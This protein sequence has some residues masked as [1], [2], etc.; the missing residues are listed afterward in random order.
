MKHT[1]D[2]LTAVKLFI[3]QLCDKRN[4]RTQSALCAVLLWYVFLFCTFPFGSVTSWDLSTVVT[5]RNGTPMS[6]SLSEEEEWSLSLPLEEMGYWM[7]RIAVA[8]EDRRY[9]SH[10]GIDLISILRAAAQNIKEGKII[11]GGSTITSQV[12]RLGIPC[13]RTIKNKAAEFY[14]AVELEYF[15]GKNEIL[16]IYLN[17]IPMGGN[18]RGVEAGSWAWFGKAAKDLTLAEAVLLT[19]ILRGPSCYRPDRHHKRATELRNRMLDMLAQQGTVTAEQAE[20]AKREPVPHERRSIPTALRQASDMVIRQRGRTA[21]RD[22]YGKIRSTIEADKQSLLLNELT[23]ALRSLPRSITAAAVLVENETGAIR[24][25]VGNAKEGTDTSTSWVDCASSYRSPGSVLKPFSYALAFEK[26]LL[27]P[28]TM[29]ADVPLHTTG[30]A[31]RNYDRYYRGAVSARTALAESLNLPAVRVMRMTG[32]PNILALYRRLGFSA[33]TKDSSWY[34]DSLVLGGCEVT[35]LETAW[36]YRTL[37]NNGEKSELCW[38]ENEKTGPGE[39]I[40]TPAACCLTIDILSDTE[41]ILPLYREILGEQRNRIAF[42]TGTSYGLRDAWTAAITKKYTLVVWFGDPEG[43]PCDA[44]IG[45][46]TAAPVARKILSRI[47]PPGAEWFE[48]PDTVGKRAVCQLSGALR[49]RS[50]PHA[51]ED[52]YIKDTSSAETCTIHKEIN[53]KASLSWPPEL[54]GFYSKPD[55]KEWSQVRI[56]SPKKNAAYIITDQSDILPLTSTGE[57]TL[58][59]F[60]DGEPAAVT[61]GENTFWKM[62]PGQHKIYVIDEKGSTDSVVF[63]VKEGNKTDEAAEMPLLEEE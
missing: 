14:R 51:V 29:L 35:A 11:S 34:G 50:C 32:A 4:R 53:G 52:L 33:F 41:R 63:T 26:G 16:E 3:L 42:K 13:E 62:T 57:G 36:A 56:L 39:K 25:Y 18:I 60:I 5:D 21:K 45:L 55:K 27:T 10:C 30:H 17:R 49:S 20:H 12:I 2:I 8:I 22:R 40:L 1:K 43:K 59:W 61:E 46:R 24:G 47:T 9:Y 37:A 19:G 38:T 48:I 44:L 6:G 7:P 28:Q 15:L 31:P 58:Y 54:A 23:A